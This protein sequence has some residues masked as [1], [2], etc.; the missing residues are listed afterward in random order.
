[1]ALFEIIIALLLVGAVLSLWA[2]RLGVPYPALLWDVAVFVLNL[3][4]VE[5]ARAALKAPRAAHPGATL[6]HA[7]RRAVAAQRRALLE[8]QARNR[9]PGADGRRAGQARNL[10]L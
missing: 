2:D 3:A 4:R 7:L 5:T 8:L 10:I 6:A 9:P 1:M